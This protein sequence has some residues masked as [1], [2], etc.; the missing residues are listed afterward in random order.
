MTEQELETQTAKIAEACTQAASRGFI[1]HL[2]TAGVSDEKITQ[3]HE[4]YTKANEK[5]AS[6]VEDMR[7]C[8]LEGLGKPV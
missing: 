2:K 7:K 3:L 1:T 5:F 6:Q 4:A 8:I